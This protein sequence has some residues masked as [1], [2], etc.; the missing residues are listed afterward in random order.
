RAIPPRLPLAIRREDINVVLL[1]I[2]LNH[3]VSGSLLDRHWPQADLKFSVHN[4]SALRGFGERWPG[5]A[6][7]LPS[8]LADLQHTV[9]KRRRR[10]AGN[11]SGASVGCRRGLASAH[12]ECDGDRPRRA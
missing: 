11:E 9:F 2:L 10:Q 7:P 6:I 8:D 5:V 1:A 3:K 12:R 4:S